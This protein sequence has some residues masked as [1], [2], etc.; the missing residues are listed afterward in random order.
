MKF[1]K[2]KGMSKQKQQKEVDDEEEK[3]VMWNYLSVYPSQ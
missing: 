2:W 3:G 1:W